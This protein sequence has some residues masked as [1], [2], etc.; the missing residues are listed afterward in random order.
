MSSVREFEWAELIPILAKA[1]IMVYCVDTAA[2]ATQI[3]E[4][5]NDRGKR[6]TDLEAIKS[7]L[8]HLI[9]LHS[10]SPEDGLA[11][12]QEQF[13][14]IYRTV[15]ALEDYSGAP[16]EDSILSYHAVSTLQWNTDEWRDPKSLVKDIIAD[17]PTKEVRPWVLGLT[18]KLTA[19]YKA[20]EKS[21]R[22]LMNVMNSRSCSCKGEWPRS[23]RC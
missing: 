5:Q 20:V 15:E 10:K 11:T 8:M 4:L 12:V 17:I 21:L 19:S 7:Y 22:L 18:T 9:Y 14:C 6:L 23:G 1:Q 13:A 2:E 3:F 16:T